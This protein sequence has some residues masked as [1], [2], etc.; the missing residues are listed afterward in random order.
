[1]LQSIGRSNETSYR[2]G[3]KNHGAYLGSVEGFKWVLSEN[4]DEAVLEVKRGIT[5]IAVTSRGLEHASS[6]EDLF[7]GLLKKKHFSCMEFFP[8][9]TLKV[10]ALPYRSMRTKM[11]SDTTGDTDKII[12]CLVRAMQEPRDARDEMFIFKCEMPLMIAR[13]WMRTRSFSYNEISRRFVALKKRAFTFFSD[14]SLI[15]NI[16]YWFSLWMY[17]R[18]IKM[19][20]PPELA[21]RFIPQS[22]MTTFW[23]AGYLDDIMHFISLRTA[24][25][26]QM[27]IRLLAEAVRGILND[28]IKIDEWYA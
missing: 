27:E 21:R 23:C 26:A 7:A 24:K 20:Q 17:R 2:I 16:Y 6:P 9:Y 19:G 10:G 13:Q 12:R 15:E 11:M 18:A 5:D 25:D 4:I 3:S 14:G 1:M 22:M 8:D 28:H